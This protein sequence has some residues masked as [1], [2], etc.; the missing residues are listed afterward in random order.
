MDVDTVLLSD[1]SEIELET[2]DKVG[3]NFTGP[4]VLKS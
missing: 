3:L 1:N 2:I 4:S